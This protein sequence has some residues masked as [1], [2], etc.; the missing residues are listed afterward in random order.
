MSTAWA[1][2]VQELLV[3]DFVL[4]SRLDRD[5]GLSN[6]LERVFRP[7]MRSGLS[8]L[9]HPNEKLCTRCGSCE[10]ACPTKAMTVGESSAEINEKLCI[11]CYCCHELCPEAAIELKFQGAGRVMH[12]FGLV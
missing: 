5:A 9:P 12:R 11:R 7:L 3:K 6:R 10:R 8:P 4:P 1:C 2:R